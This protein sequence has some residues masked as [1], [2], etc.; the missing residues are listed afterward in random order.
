MIITSS[1]QIKVNSKPK[2]MQHT[3]AAAAFAS[4]VTSLSRPPANASS[5][6]AK[7]RE[8]TS[9]SV[10][11]WTR[12]CSVMMQGPS[13]PVTTGSS[14]GGASLRASKR[15]AS[16]VSVTDIVKWEVGWGC[17]WGCEWV[18]EVELRRP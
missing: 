14:T 10:C 18:D 1:R 4:S 16:R 2:K 13:S 5:A 9:D 17:E 3:R 11:R 7:P 8:A 12:P 15:G 6:S